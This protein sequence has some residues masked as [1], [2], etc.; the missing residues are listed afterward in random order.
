MRPRHIIAC[1]LVLALCGSAAA[2]SNASTTQNSSRR[3]KSH[4]GGSEAEFRKAVE[5]AQAKDF[6][7]AEPLLQKAAEQ[8]PKNYQAW[9]YLGYVYNETNRRDDAIAAYQK[10]VELQPSVF[11]SNL[12]LAVLLA[13]QGASE[14]G[15]YLHKAAKLNP[16]PE[17]QETLARAWM[18]L[19]NK[20]KTSDP[21]GAID[22]YQTLAELRPKDATSLLDLG[23]FLESRRDLPG[24]EKAY[25]DALARDP[26]SPDALA[27]LSNLYLQ[28]DHLPEA[29]QTLQAFVKANPQSVN[30]HLQLGRVYRREMKTVEAAA[31]FEK[32]LELKPGD[33]DALRELAAVQLANKNYAAAEASLRNLIAKRPDDAELQ[34]LLGST[35]TRES[36]FKE[37][38][39]AYLE[40]IKLRPSWG[41]A[42]GELAVAASEATNYVGAI[43]ALNARAKYLP[44]TPG[45]YF[46]RGTCFDHL[47]AYKEATEQYKQFL[48]VAGGK[49]PDEEWKA[50]HRLIAIDPESRKK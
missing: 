30:G 50:R 35:L 25:K 43:Q 23:Q 4:S 14:A 15:R 5:A 13:Q 22:A 21:A 2:Q 38:E 27:L 45:T 36:K 33:L 7:T 1:T 29:E 12:N 16:T 28:A 18:L 41:E 20:L 17:Q 6:A 19:A 26:N 47:R 48:Q 31:E 32:A 37:A 49:Y 39:S 3:S 9:F 42:Y 11:E 40:A 8:D 44:E 46:L 24:A 34:F 10:A